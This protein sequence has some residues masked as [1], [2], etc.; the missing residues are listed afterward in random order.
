M[1]VHSL[2]ETDSWTDSWA[3]QLAVI[4]PRANSPPRSHTGPFRGKKQLWGCLQQD[5]TGAE[6][7]RKGGLAFQ[8]QGDIQKTFSAYVCETILKD[9]PECLVCAE[10]WGYKRNNR[11]FGYRCEGFF[12]L[13]L[14]TSSCGSDQQTV[15]Q[16]V[17]FMFPKNPMN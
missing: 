6:Q 8:W 17:P 15:L 12:F 4:L 16:I 10:L 3:V 11:T 14:F 5:H 2:D 9:S 1:Q 13:N 7:L